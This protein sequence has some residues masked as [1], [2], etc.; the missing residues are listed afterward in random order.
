[1]ANIAVHFS[2]KSDDWATPVDLFDQL[3]QEFAFDW[4]VAA[5]QANTRIGP[6][7]YFGPD[8]H[9]PDFRD[10]LARSWGCDE[11]DELTWT[12]WCNPPYSLSKEFIAKAH[13]EARLGHA[14][15]VMLLPARTDTRAFHQYIYDTEKH[16]ARPG[17]E[18]RFLKGRLKFGGATSGAPFPSMIV[19]FAAGKVY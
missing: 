19:V 12:V 11:D 17:V 9:N 2:R 18:I 3:D 13:E 5:T 10:A 6:R 16:R 4:D 1:M 15:T 8:H 14:T 7:R